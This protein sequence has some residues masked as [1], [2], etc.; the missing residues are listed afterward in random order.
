MLYV[1]VHHPNVCSGSDSQAL[2]NYVLYMY[3][4]IVHNILYMKNSNTCVC[5]C[6]G[7]CA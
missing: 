7:C 6:V 4:Y 1:R 2:H 5:V 3:M